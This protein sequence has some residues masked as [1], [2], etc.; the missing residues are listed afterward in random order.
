MIG[1]VHSTT[2]AVRASPGGEAGGGALNTET[3]AM[4][5][6]AN[7]T[8]LLAR[9]AAHEALAASLRAKVAVEAAFPIGAWV[10]YA[11]EVRGEVENYV[12]DAP[13][14]LHVRVDAV[15]NDGAARIYTVG[16]KY[17]FNIDNLE[18]DAVPEHPAS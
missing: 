11:R 3:N 4:A 2:P 17:T 1:P 7:A 13:Q 15:L 14:Y 12:A 18:V 10:T 8:V 16:S 6:P 9:A 5:E